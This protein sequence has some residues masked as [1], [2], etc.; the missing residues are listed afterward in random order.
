MPLL[1]ST[2]AALHCAGTSAVLLG[3]T[4]GDEIVAGVGERT[5]QQ[6]LRPQDLTT[7]AGRFSSEPG[8]NRSGEPIVWID[9]GSAFAIHRLRPGASRQQRAARLASNDAMGRRLSAGC[10]V[11]PE[12]FYDAIVAPLLGHY[13]G[14]VYVMPE[15]GVL[16]NG[17]M[18]TPQTRQPG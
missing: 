9:Y 7:P 17:R 6:V 18:L 4:L 14:V 13:R 8:Q 5:Q 2:T 11:V 12:A 16:P 1:R 10:V 3:Q 15:S